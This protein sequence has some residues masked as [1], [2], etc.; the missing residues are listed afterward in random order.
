MKA[1]NLELK[2]GKQ[3]LA[4]QVTGVDGPSLGQWDPMLEVLVVVQVV[5]GVLTATIPTNIAH[6]HTTHRLEITTGQSMRVVWVCVYQ[7]MFK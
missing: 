5:C 7:H 1:V 6:L 4:T 3:L 2:L